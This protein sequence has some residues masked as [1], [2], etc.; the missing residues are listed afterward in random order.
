MSGD[1]YNNSFRVNSLILS[2]FFSVLM[3]GGCAV[4]AAK[5]EAERIRAKRN[6]QPA[7]YTA[8]AEKQNSASEGR[9]EIK[10][11]SPADAIRTFYSNLREKRF[12]EA[13]FL[14]NLRPAIEGLTDTELKDL[15]VDF[16]RLAQ[17]VPSDIQING[18]IISGE[19][20][21]V[22][23]KL[24]DDE[25]GK[26]ELKEFKLAREKGGWLILL[27]QK[28]VEEAIKKEGKNYFFVLRMEVHQREAEAMMQRI[29]KAQIVY[30]IQNGG[31]FADMKSLIDGGLLPSDVQSPVSTGYRYK[32]SLSTDKKKFETSAEPEIYNKTGRLSYF[33]E[34]DGNNQNPRLKSADLGGK[35]L[36]S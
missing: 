23:A 29:V 25:T 21:T 10:S 31:L 1:I 24:P 13:I 12:R 35:P 36:K 20:A 6:E 26:L 4:E 28:E 3:I 27:V 19:M 7:I 8:V 9:I 18:E 14:T 15:E 11:H 22:T 5:I 32:I 34:V 2:L 33:L 30:S 16:A 17:T